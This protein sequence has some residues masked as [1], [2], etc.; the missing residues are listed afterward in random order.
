MIQKAL[1]KSPPAV[2]SSIQRKETGFTVMEMLV[3]IMIAGILGGMTISIYNSLRPK[4][5]LTSVSRELNTMFQKARLA[6]IRDGEPVVGVIETE[7][8]APV[9]DYNPNGIKNEW[10][11][12]KTVDVYGVETEI[13]SYQMFRGFPPIHFWGHSE[14]EI[15]KDSANTFRN[16]IL[17]YNFDGSVFST[18]ALRISY[19]KTGTRN[20]L[21]IAVPTQSGI[22]IVRK[23]LKVDDRPKKAKSQ[24]FFEETVASAARRRA[25]WVWY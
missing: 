18:G 10:L 21:E 9:T 15:Q 1:P 14:D 11:V 3:V 17:A 23:F 12:L 4:M 19:A 22:P 24:T 8:G 16:K 2:G 13:N 25:L 20:T 6:A 7:L 5:V